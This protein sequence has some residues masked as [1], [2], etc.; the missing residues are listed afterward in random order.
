MRT[1]FISYACLTKLNNTVRPKQLANI[2]YLKFPPQTHQT[3]NIGMVLFVPCLARKAKC[4]RSLQYRL[5]FRLT[6]AN[7]LDLLIDGR[8]FLMR[9]GK[10]EPTFIKHF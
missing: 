6:L 4:Q 5:C 8:T 9:K 1:V 10:F 3:Y 2:Q 7:E